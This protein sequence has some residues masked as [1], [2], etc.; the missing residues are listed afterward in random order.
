MQHD[1]SEGL[2]FYC[3]YTCSRPEYRLI[4]LSVTQQ[5]IN[6][7]PEQLVP[8]LTIIP[9]RFLEI[10]RTLI[11]SELTV[12]LPDVVLASSVQ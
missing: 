3:L 1:F 7:L 5:F 4:I 11:P 6:H 8:S 2:M 10:S 12:T 9:V